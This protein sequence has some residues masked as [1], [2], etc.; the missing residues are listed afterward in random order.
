MRKHRAWNQI[1]IAYKTACLSPYPIFPISPMTG[2]ATCFDPENRATEHTP[3][4]GGQEC[5]RSCTRWKRQRRSGARRSSAAS[6]RRPTLGPVWI[7]Q[8]RCPNIHRLRCANCVSVPISASEG[9]LH[10]LR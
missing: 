7:A 2:H 9:F 6:T 5:P 8:M 1:G 4:G 3:V 10:R